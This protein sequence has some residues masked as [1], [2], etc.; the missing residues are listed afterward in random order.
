MTAPYYSVCLPLPG[1][2]QGNRFPYGICGPFMG[3][4]EAEDAMVALQTILP[5]RELA[6]ICGRQEDDAPWLLV[7][8]EKA[9]AKLREK[10]KSRYEAGSAKQ[11]TEQG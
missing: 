10:T 8:Q 7:D 3:A 4:H 11:I 9:R 2:P 1:Y 5:G 6:I